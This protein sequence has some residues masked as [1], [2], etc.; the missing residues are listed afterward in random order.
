M[1][2]TTASDWVEEDRRSARLLAAITRPAGTRLRNAAAW[3]FG[4]LI[5]GYAAWISDILSG[6]LLA[7]LP[8]LAGALAMMLVPAGF[9]HLPEFLWA[10]AETVAMAFLGTLLGATL[11]LPL[12][13]LC[14]RTTLPIRVLQFGFRRISDTLRGLDH[15]IWAL[16]FVRAIGLGPLAGIFAIA[17]VDI[18]TLSKLYA[19]AIDNAKKGAVEGVRASGGT[20]L[21]SFSLGILPQVLPNMLSVTLYMWESNTRSATILGIV[22]AGGIGYQLA[23]RL[24]VYEF[25]QASLIIILIIGTVYLI[26][27]LS[28]TLRARLIGMQGSKH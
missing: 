7:G 10:L 16:V 27:M 2:D 11:A 23:D 24:R 5:L 19:E 9:E 12:A 25:G 8:K 14:A 18:G 3:F 26:D 6:K 1:A 21:D 17:L 15:L 4:F 13:L 28:S 20:W 22:G